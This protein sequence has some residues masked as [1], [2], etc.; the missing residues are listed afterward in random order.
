MV[1]SYFSVMIEEAIQTLS[2]MD[3]A[4]LVFSI[5]PHPISFHI[6]DM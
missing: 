3:G 6:K 5:Q 4:F 2:R 1:Y